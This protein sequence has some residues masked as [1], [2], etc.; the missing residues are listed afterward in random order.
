MEVRAR[1]LQCLALVEVA[2]HAAP[3]APSSAICI[4]AFADSTTPRGLFGPSG[5][6]GPPPPPVGC[7]GP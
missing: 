1:K 3:P 5:V 6:L 7:W 2:L 4:S